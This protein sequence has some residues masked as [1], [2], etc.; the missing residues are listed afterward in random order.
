MRISRSNLADTLNYIGSIAAAHASNKGVSIKVDADPDLEG[1]IDA[2]QIQQ[3][4]LNLVLNAIDACPSG[5]SVTLRA[6][7]NGQ[8]A[9][10]LEVSNNAG[11][12]PARSHG[13]SV[14]AVLHDQGRW[15]G[16][17]AG[18]RAQRRPR[19]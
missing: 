17:G 19:P 1:D 5:G 14:R 3:A 9:S 8:G 4:L 10:R 13:A 16:P 6:T 12:N 11:P 15:N 18:N 2:G 7:P